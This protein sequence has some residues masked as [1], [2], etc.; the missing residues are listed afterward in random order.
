MTNPTQLCNVPVDTVGA[1][2]QLADVMGQPHFLRH[3][4]GCETD[5]HGWLVSGCVTAA[6]GVAAVGVVARTPHCASGPLMAMPRSLRSMS[7][8]FCAPA[9]TVKRAVS[10]AAGPTNATTPQALETHP[11]EK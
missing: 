9:Q 10:H 8:W 7:L 4:R 3:V 11:G 5:V 1:F 2:D 6:N